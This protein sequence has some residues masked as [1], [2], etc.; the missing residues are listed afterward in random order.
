MPKAR[1][2][3]DK[4]PRPGML[5]TGSLGGLLRRCRLSES[6]VVALLV[7]IGFNNRSDSED[8]NLHQ[9]DAFHSL[10]VTGNLPAVRFSHKAIELLEM[11]LDL[12]LECRE[13][14]F[15]VGGVNAWK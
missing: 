10:P 3:V 14:S 15:E 8:F 4:R 12:R 5:L 11:C 13:S 1:Q 6:P 9:L 2:R 7:D